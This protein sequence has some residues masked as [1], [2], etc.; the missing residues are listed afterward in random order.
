MRQL[1]KSQAGGVLPAVCSSQRKSINSVWVIPESDNQ[2]WQGWFP[3]KYNR[4]QL[5]NPNVNCKEVDMRTEPGEIWQW[6][7]Y[8]AQLGAEVQKSD[9]GLILLFWL[10]S[11]GIFS[12]GVL[13][14]VSLYSKIQR[15]FF[16]HLGSLFPSLCSCFW[17]ALLCRFGV[18]QLERV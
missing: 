12:F 16:I 15:L 6:F 4:N 13:M 17:N 3:S 2:Q 8:F 1:K 11:A 9:Q 18:F 7:Q 10:F 14:L 5:Y